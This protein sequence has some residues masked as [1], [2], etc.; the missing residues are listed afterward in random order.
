MHSSKPFGPQE[1]K[2]YAG[3]NIAINIQDWKFKK[4]PETWQYIKEFSHSNGEAKNQ[5]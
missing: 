4:F 5:H 1:L 3:I 2:S